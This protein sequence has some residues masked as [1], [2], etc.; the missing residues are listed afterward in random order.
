MQEWS[1]Q[2]TVCG[3]PTSVGAG[4]DDGADERAGVDSARSKESGLERS[5]ARASERERQ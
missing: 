1:W 2:K 5:A 4:E 3:V